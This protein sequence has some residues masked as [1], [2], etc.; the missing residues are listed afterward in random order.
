MIARSALGGKIRARRKDLGLTQTVLAERAG[1]S[2]SYLNLIESGKRPIGGKLL[3]TIAQLLNTTPDELDSDEERRLISDLAELSTDPVVRPAG[4]PAA[5][6]AALVARHPH[7]ARALVALH[8]AYRAEARRA[9]EFA[10][11]MNQDPVLRQALYQ[12]LGNVSAIRSAAEILDDTDDLGPGETAQFQRILVEESARV[13]SASR[14][15]AAFF[16]AETAESPAVTATEEVDDFLAESGNYFPA[17]E[18]SAESLRFSAR[19]EDARL[20]SRLIDYL[21]S[22]HGV[23]IERAATPGDQEFRH[24]SRYDPTGRRLVVLDGA[25]EP[26]RRFEIARVA[27][28][29]SLGRVIQAEVDGAP[30]LRTEEARVRAVRALTSYAAGAILLPYDAFHAEATALRYDV[31]A[32]SR[33]FGASFEQTAHR[34]TTLRKPGAEGVPFAFMRSD[35]AGYVTKRLALP[36]LALPRQGGACPLWTIYRA[37]QTPGETQRQLVEFPSG[38]RFLFAA[39]AVAK[40]GGAFDQPRHLLSIMLACD[41]IYA[42]RLVYGDGLALTTRAAPTAVGPTCRLCPRLACAYRQEAPSTLLAASG[43]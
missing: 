35:P 34:L 26:T 18:A 20:K 37:F 11:R 13:S 27:A 1:V 9:D 22:R 43:A 32:L 19:I 8:R 30:T 42:D 14:S 41:A 21:S 23:R 24:Y 39:R 10:D 15:I 16:D 7:W 40:Q 6:A 2:P 17:L 33:R 36:D 5:E 25:P 12:L 28:E 29:L 4:P 38:A 3:S 31:D